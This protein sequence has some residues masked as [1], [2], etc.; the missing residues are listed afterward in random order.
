[1]RKIDLLV[2][3]VGIIGAIS[4]VI[5]SSK[6]GY[7]TSN[8]TIVA[9]SI[10]V[11][12]TIDGQ[13]ENSP[14]AVGARVSSNELLVRIHNGRFD[15]SRFVEFESQVG[16]LDA[17]I[18]NVTAQ[19]ETSESQ[20]RAFKERA[21]TY[22]AWLLDDA[23]LKQVEFGAR[24]EVAKNRNE[25][26]SQNVKRSAQLY[27]KNLNS[28][29]NMQLARIE[30]S[31]AEK[32]VKL[33]QAQYQRSLLM[34][35][36]LQQ[37]GVFF[38]NGDTS[39]WAKMV[40]TLKVRIQDNRTKLASLQAQLKRAR[41]QANVER[42]RINSSYAEEH[43]APF[44]GMV[45][46]SYVTRGTRVT[47]GTN[48]FQI[49]DCTQPVI[50][51]PIPDNRISE[52]SVG[53]KVTVYPTDSDQ[54]LP[55]KISYVTSGALIGNDAS[56]QIQQDLI[57]RGNRAIVALD[58]SKTAKLDTNQEQSCETARKAV[59]VIHTQSTF[60]T[61]TAWVSTNLPEVASWISATSTLAAETMDEVLRGKS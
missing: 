41:V 56:I 15:R 39:Y 14:P 38:E 3:L 28:E 44:S 2:L 12:S 8:A 54:A 31:I 50:I 19:I 49:L 4:W 11:T 20:L 30:S 36:A 9:R 24:L 48:L 6:D 61:V 16:F 25:L 40:D 23:K 21:R 42:E 13:V 46:A 60:D 10:S 26:K 57:M 33:S 58:D 5:I 1:M 43:R 34:L 32:Q 51:I 7:K 17:E 22:S 45:N 27:Q 35:G 55:G 37:D 29:A 53:L 59:V 18:K 47:S 52:F